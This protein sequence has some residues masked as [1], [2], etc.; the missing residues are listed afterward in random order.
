LTHSVFIY[1]DAVIWPWSYA[2]A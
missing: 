2:V 1:F